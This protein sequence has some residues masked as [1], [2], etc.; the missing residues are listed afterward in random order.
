MKSRFVNLSLLRRKDNSS[1]FGR[2]GDEKCD[3][4]R[5]WTNNPVQKPLLMI[6]GRN[7]KKME[8]LGRLAD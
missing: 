1:A 4:T 8:A 5:R 2:V 3:A 6:T 7:V